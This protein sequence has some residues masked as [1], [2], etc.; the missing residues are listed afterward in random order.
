VL[1]T[2]CLPMSVRTCR[3]A[4]TGPLPGPVSCVLRAGPVHDMGARCDIA[5]LDAGGTQLA[6]LIEVGLVVCPS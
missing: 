3:L 2:A 4:A 6:E 5:L 1:G